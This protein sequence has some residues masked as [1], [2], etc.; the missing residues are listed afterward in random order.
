MLVSEYEKAVLSVIL[1]NAV[2]RERIPQRICFEL[3]FDKFDPKGPHGIIYRAIQ[4][5][6]FDK[7]TPNIPTVA[8][9]LGND[10]DRIGGEEYLQSLLSF[11]SIMGVSGSEGFETWVQVVDNA[12]RLRQLGLVID[13]Y[14]QMYDDFQRLVNEVKDVDEFIANVLSEI[15]KGV[16]CLKSSYTHISEVGHEERLR[17]EKERQGLSVDL[18][19]TGWPSLER[20]HIPRPSTYGVISGLSSIGKTQFAL[21]IALG[22]AL[23]LKHNNLP[24]CIGIN[25][26]ESKAWRLHRRMACCLAGVD[27][28]ELTSS[29]LSKDTFKRYLDTFDIIDELPI[30]FDDNP[31][32]N[33]TKLVWNA[34][35]MHLEH[36][37]RILGIAD[38]IELFA[39]E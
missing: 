7:Q 2:S 13:S 29:T 1:R 5:T 26:L 32:M 39:D 28:D 23:Y 25:E 10:I 38:Y 17:L 37:P 22:A 14:A 6:V 33:S 4:N 11:L 34:T 30:Y 36:G 31:S 18:I 19:P 21:Q 8:A 15:N 9:R 35:A 3:D 16:G 27:S 12:G 20:Y 24:G